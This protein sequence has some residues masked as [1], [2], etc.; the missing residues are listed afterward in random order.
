[1][2][3]DVVYLG[4]DLHCQEKPEAGVRLHRVEFLFQLHQPPGGQVDVFQHY[5][6]AEQKKNK[7]TQDYQYKQQSTQE[8]NTRKW[9]F[10][11]LPARFDSSVD[12]SVSLIKALSRTCGQWKGTNMNSMLNKLL[13]NNN[14][15]RFV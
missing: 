1:M 2:I 8:E 3:S 14:Q 13:E 5:P 9:K 11:Y 12:V 10:R 7:K 4:V 15:V 6:P